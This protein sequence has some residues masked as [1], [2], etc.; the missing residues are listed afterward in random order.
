VGYLHD[1]GSLGQ[2]SLAGA[3]AF[4]APILWGHAPPLPSGRTISAAADRGVAWIYTEA[5]GGGFARPADVASFELGVLNVMQWLGMLEGDP[6]TESV[7]HHLIGAGDMDE[8]IS[9]S[10]DGMFQREVRLLETVE[11]G[12][13]L[14]RIMDPFGATV[15]EVRA[16]GDGV[17]IM[18]RRVPR[19]RIGDTLAHVTGVF[20][21]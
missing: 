5:P 2:R 17:V 6:E 12:Q 18:L 15:S 20:G 9:A 7:A 19:V 8:A 10:A 21:G 3:K 1:E 14:G 11:E 16:N 13:R 4:G